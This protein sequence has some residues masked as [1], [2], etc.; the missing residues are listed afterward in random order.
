[1][2]NEDDDVSQSVIGFAQSYVLLLKQLSPTELQRREDQI[3]VNS[4]NL[5]NFSNKT[6]ARSGAY[7]YNG[8]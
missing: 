6:V 1:M 3:K 8:I 7:I 2:T 4:C 5:L